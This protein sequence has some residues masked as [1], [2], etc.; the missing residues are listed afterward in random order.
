MSGARNGI[1]TLR[2]SGRSSKACYRWKREGVR[3]FVHTNFLT[4]SFFHDVHFAPPSYTTL[5]S[6]A[7]ASPPYCGQ[8]RAFRYPAARASASL[9]NGTRLRSDTFE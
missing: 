6:S 4:G 2:G 5:S 1:S 8:F 3:K 9:L 7:I